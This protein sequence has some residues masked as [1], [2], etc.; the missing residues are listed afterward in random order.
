MTEGGTR[1]EYVGVGKPERGGEIHPAVRA[2]KGALAGWWE[3][4]GPGSVE[5]S[6]VDAHGRIL[7]RI[8][9]EE[10]KQIFARSA[11]TWRKIGKTLGV[12]STVV[13]FSVGG[14]GIFLSVKGFQ[15]PNE[16]QAVGIA[17]LFGLTRFVSF[18]G[19][20][21]EERRRK[22]LAKIV[23]GI[24]LVGSLGSLVGTGPAH[25]VSRLTARAA[26]LIGQAGAAGGNYVASGKAGEH[27]KKVGGALEK[28]ATAAVKYAAQHPEE[29][30]KTMETVEDMRRRRERERVLQESARQRAAE[31]AFDQRYQEWL[32]G[33][34]P[35][36]K[37]YYRDS[38]IKPSHEE[39]MKQTGDKGP[40]VEVPKMGKSGR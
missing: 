36:L 5:K 39:F 31:A 13:D 26:G 23:P 12:A 11:Q 25:I 19:G 33:M 16:V 9:G 24:P 40:V 28:G 35:N 14:L 17:S 15:Q 1:V 6:W 18:G 7:G 38:H 10:R 2:V 21:S 22:T 27:A 3:R 4:V 20:D 32:A 8:E 37:A 29:I 34:D 30:R